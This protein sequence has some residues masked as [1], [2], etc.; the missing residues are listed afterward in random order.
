MAYT[1][2]KHGDLQPV[3]NFDAGVTANGAGTSPADVNAALSG[4]TVQPQGPKLDFF[5]VTANAGMTTAQLASTITAIQQLATVYIYEY[6]DAA[7]SGDD[8][9]AVA[10]YPTGA[11][12]T[13]SLDD[14]I[15]TATG[16]ANVVVTTTAT[17]TN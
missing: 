7:G 2:R 12:D 3:A 8:T 1:T 15:T 5:T 16:L 6:T 9:V 4:V 17:F 13:T 10:V 11:W 14:A